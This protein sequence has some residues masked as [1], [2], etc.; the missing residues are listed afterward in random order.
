MWYVL[1]AANALSGDA[2]L[3]AGTQLKVPEMAASKN[4]ATSFRPYNPGEIV[5]STSPT[6]PI[7]PP[8]GCGAIG[9]VIMIVIAIVVTVYTAGAASGLAGSLWSAGITAM[10]GGS[11]T[12]VGA[13]ALGGFV[14]SVASQAAGSLMGV[15]SFSWRKAVGSGIASGLTAGIAGG[16]SAGGG[17]GGSTAKL[18]EGGASFSKI[19]TSA[20]GNALAGYAG[21][22]IAGVKDN[23][24]SWKAI[25]ASAVTSV[26]A[27]KINNQLGTL[28]DKFSGSNQIIGQTIGGM[29]SGAVNLHVRRQF[30]FDDKVDYGMIAADAFGNALGN[31]IVGQAIS[32]TSGTSIKPADLDWRKTAEMRMRQVA[33]EEKIEPFGSTQ[34]IYLD[35]NPSEKSSSGYSTSSRSSVRSEVAR[36]TASERKRLSQVDVNENVHLDPATQRERTYKNV[37]MSFKILEDSKLVPIPMPSSLPVYSPLVSGYAARSASIE[38]SRQS[39]ISHWNNSKL[40]GVAVTGRVFANVGYNILSSLN[41]V[42]SLITDADHRNNT[43]YALNEAVNNPDR[44]YQGMVSR[45]SDMFDRSWQENLESGAVFGI[46]TLATAGTGLIVRR[47]DGA[48]GLVDEVGANAANANNSG[49]YFF[50][51]QVL[52]Y[53]DKVEATLGQKN[54]AQFFMPVNDSVLVTDAASAYRYSGGAPSLERAYTSGGNVFGV[55]FPLDG[56]RPRLPSTSDTTLEHFLEGGNTALKLPENGG[57]LINQTREFVIHGGSAMPSGTVLFRLAPDGTR[58]PIRSW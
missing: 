43:V 47:A 10:G 7:P 26:V 51:Q 33:A 4:D 58:V 39:A 50:D 44:V 53:I 5:G 49:V 6:L 2:D 36:L 13:A 30:G 45:T 48:L 16:I 19:A 9:M 12:L 46:E 52:P 38:G 37:T 20:V 8:S 21:N 24:F 29:V 57:Y 56:F 54:S 18:I 42:G 32:R 14:G 34:T 35:E 41:S 23:S 1:A 27:G 15:A 25:A 31:A 22:K 55:E 28:Y 40:P 3:T 11:L 17:L